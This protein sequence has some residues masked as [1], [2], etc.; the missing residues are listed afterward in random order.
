MLEG[1]VKEASLALSSCQWHKDAHL[2]QVIA[3]SPKGKFMKERYSVQD[4]F[5]PTKPARITFVERVV[6]NDKLVGALTTPGKQ[7]VVYGHSGSGKTTLLVNKL[8]QLYDNHVTTRCVSGLTFDQLLLDAFDQL[9][10]FYDAER[11]YAAKRNGTSSLQ[12]EYVGIK[13]QTGA[14]TSSERQTKQQRVL[15]PQLTPPTLAKFLGAARCCWVLED[16]HKIEPPEKRR[17]AQVMKVF[18]DMSDE[19]SFLKIIAIGAVGTARQVV[20]YDAEMRNRVAEIH[21]PLMTDAEIREIPEKGEAL[22][23]FSMQSRVKNGIVMYS[24]GLASVCHQLCLNICFAARIYETLPHHA[25]IETAVL[26]KALDRY[27]EDASDTLKAS[28]DKAFRQLRKGKFDNGRLIFEALLRCGQD[29]ATHAEILAKIKESAPD[30]PRGNLTLYL[31][32]LQTDNRGALIRYMAASGRYSFSDP[33]Y[34]AFA[35]TLFEQER[36]KGQP[37]TEGDF[38]VNR[39][40]FARALNRLFADASTLREVK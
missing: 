9:N 25:E 13:L 5:T 39:E 32:Q 11:V 26:E 37:Q 8:H 38:T 16:F 2:F 7:L 4:V 34:R 10:N 35:L 21:V 1:Q 18:M 12:A 36:Q 17:L 15:P 40:E 14:Q 28:F 23:N 29:G 20:E 6:I 24:N 3:R 19:Y 22:L 31:K 33:I 30:Y 27:L